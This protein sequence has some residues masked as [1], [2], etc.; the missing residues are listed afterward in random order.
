MVA[1][2][3]LDLG[4]GVDGGQQVGQQV[5]HERGLVVRGGVEGHERHA[6]HAQLGVAQRQQQLRHAGAQQ[7]VDRLRLRTPVRRLLFFLMKCDTWELAF[8]YINS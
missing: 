7:P 6:P 8:N 2:T 1:R 4:L 3:H 5:A